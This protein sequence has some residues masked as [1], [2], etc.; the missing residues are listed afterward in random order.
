M[1]RWQ[2][3]LM[4][5]LVLMLALWE[6]AGAWNAGFVHQDNNWHQAGVSLD[7]TGLTHWDRAS[8]RW[9]WAWQ[10]AHT[11]S[12]RAFHVVNLLLH[13]IA[14]ALVAWLVWQVSASPLG[15][16]A[17]GGLML[18][19]PI[20]AQSAVY[21]SGRT[22]LFAAIGMVAAVAVTAR[23]WT[24][25]TIIAGI[26]A[27]GV[28]LTGKESAV[29]LIAL[30]PIVQRRWSWLWAAWAVLLVVVYG[31]AASRVY[32]PPNVAAWALLQAATAWR[33]LAVAVTT[34]GSTVDYDV[35]QLS[36]AAQVLS[37][38]SLT[39]AIWQG[40]TYHR[41]RPMIAMG[42]LWIATVILPRL[43]VFTPGSNFP[44]HQFYGAMPGL[45]LIA[46]GI[47]SPKQVPLW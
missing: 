40:W 39:A 25:V 13:L 24:V 21:L 17:A 10:A 32:A 27:A 30:V 38:V 9:S 26:V 37:V 16:W 31:M 34:V 1:T 28:G 35:T 36:F 6:F 43:C 15:A 29:A 4:A 23:R 2:H 14:S 5:A 18:L 20:Q 45:S 8:T 44:E 11:P 19:N 12:A 42:A 33:V 7:P 46:A 22:E 3:G 41:T 47:V